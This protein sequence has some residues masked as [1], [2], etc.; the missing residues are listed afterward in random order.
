MKN[1][2]IIKPIFCITDDNK[3]IINEIEN[4]LNLIIIDDNAKKRNL[5]V[6]SKVRSIYSSLAI[7]ANSLSLESVES[8]IDNKL[9]LGDRKEIQEVKNANELY[10]HIIEY[11]WKSELDFLKAHTLMMKYFDDDNGYYRN[12]G[13]GVKRGNEVIYSAPESILVP[14]LMKSLFQFM[15]DNENEIHPLILS[16]IFH[17]YFVYIHPFSDGNGRMARFWVSLIL[18]KWN[19]KFEY[20]PIEEEIYLNQQKYYDSIAQCHVNGN[21]NAFIDFM[22]MCINSSL[23][24]ITQKTT[25]KLNN[26]QLKI[27]E[28]IK[29]NPKITRNELAN[30]LNITSDGVK[31]NLKK[32]VDNKIIERI[33]PDNGGYWEI[34]NT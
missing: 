15:I 5:L 18:T 13:E 30:K 11:D 26:N 1:I 6:K 17:Y 10:E 8:I 4:K 32:L 25:Q 2:D 14:S 19:Q 9:V 28:L 12:H 20:I 33:G 29:E 23:E 34:K 24:Q 21:V 22:L 31:Y 16:C 3:K 27:I 7:E